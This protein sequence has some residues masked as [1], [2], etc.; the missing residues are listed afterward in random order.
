MV[1][2]RMS[3]IKFKVKCPHCGR[4]QLTITYRYKTNWLNNPVLKGKRKECVYC[5]K[6]I[7]IRKCLIK[8]INK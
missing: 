6:S 4:E 5:G 7:G 1:E 3:G 2:R 8:K